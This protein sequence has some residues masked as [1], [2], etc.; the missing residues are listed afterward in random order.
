MNLM[1]DGAERRDVGQVSFK[2]RLGTLR[3]LLCAGVALLVPFWVVGQIAR[4]VFLLTALCFYI[5]SAFLSAVLPVCAVAQLAGK[6]RRLAVVLACLALPPCVMVGL[7][8][9]RM[10]VK[11]PSAERGDVR[12]V[13]WNVGG[14]LGR[15]EPRDF[16]A[17]RQADLY[18]LSEVRNNG[19]QVEGFRD[20]L[21]SR[22]QSAVF[23]NLAVVGT[24]RLRAD[25]WLLDRNRTKVQAVTWECAGRS[26]RL[27]VVDLPSE[28]H[29]PRDPLLREVN[30]LIERHQPDLIVGDFNA[31]RRS[32]ALC[33][34]PAGYRHAYDSVGAGLGYT[35]PVPLPMYSLDQCIYSPRIVPARYELLTCSQSDHRLQVLDFSWHA[36]D[37][38]DKMITDGMHFPRNPHDPKGVSKRP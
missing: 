37:S 36:T 4:D 5:P 14:M 35:W 27:L 32:R 34:L 21:G 6:R 1:A 23:G 9:N 24:G 7:V 25:G 17:A 38:S 18:V 29:I 22:Y 31:P 2:S 8:E 11:L 12:V 16:L 28:P 10:F 33:A 3:D 26:L 20:R 13:H 15:K 19:R 30:A